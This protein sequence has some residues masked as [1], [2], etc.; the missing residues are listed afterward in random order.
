MNKNKKHFVYRLPP[1]PIYDLEVYE[2]WLS[3]MAEKGLILSERGFF[4][5]LVVFYKETPRKIRYRF[6]PATSKDKSHDGYISPDYDLQDFYESFDWFYVT[7]HR[8]FF[9]Y[10]C[11]NENAPELNTDSKLQALSLKYVQQQQYTHIVLLIGYA[12]FLPLVRNYRFILLTILETG[13]DWF[14]GFCLLLLWCSYNSIKQTIK[15]HQLKKKLALGEELNHQKDWIKR[16]KMYRMNLIGVLLAILVLGGVAIVRNI[17]DDKNIIT[18]NLSNV[19]ETLP[20]PTIKNFEEL[21]QYTLLHQTPTSE[22]KFK[23]DWLAPEMIYLKEY[24]TIRFENGATERTSLLI[25][26]YDT[27]S[28]M[29]AKQLVNEILYDATHSPEYYQIIEIPTLD[30]DL[31]TAYYVK[32]TPFCKILIIQK[33]HIM[34]IIDF[35]NIEG[36]DLTIAEWSKIF[37][38]SIQ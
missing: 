28:P 34:M 15:L 23:S 18:F 2:S 7:S 21:G 35:E 29:I 25:K 31:A 26:Y 9:I 22:L 10:R 37:A 13:S 27:A 4:L 20:F 24:A 38:D 16:A 3:S 1:C 17:E 14:L 36:S 8:S 12:A 32:N 33:N 6:E 11:E 30:V 19:V 5:G